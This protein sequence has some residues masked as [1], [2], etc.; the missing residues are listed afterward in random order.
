MEFWEDLG[1]F[2]KFLPPLYNVMLLIYFIYINKHWMT[3]LLV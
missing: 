2:L 1:K 3:Q